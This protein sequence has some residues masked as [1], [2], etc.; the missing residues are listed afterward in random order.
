MIF[1]LKNLS[2]RP[3]FES[4]MCA[5]QSPFCF[6]NLVKTAKLQAVK[7]V[8]QPRCRR[9]DDQSAA[10]IKR[11]LC[12]IAGEMHFIVDV[13]EELYFGHCE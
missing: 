10:V 11:T 8:R 3:S 2:P 13:E 9:I 12:Q 6:K 5:G 7:F 4:P 1:W